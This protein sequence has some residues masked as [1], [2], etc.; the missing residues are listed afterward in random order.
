MSI[1]AL[2]SICKI[3]FKTFSFENKSKLS[4]SCF[5]K[6]FRLRHLFC[7]SSLSSDFNFLDLIK[8]QK[9]FRIFENFQ[10]YFELKK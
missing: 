7:K 8:N 2:S 5:R 6:P 10:T 3:S 4:R 9:Y 1:G